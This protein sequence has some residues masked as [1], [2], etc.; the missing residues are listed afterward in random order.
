MYNKAKQILL[1]EIRKFRVKAQMRRKDA[2]K[3]D[4]DADELQ[5]QADKL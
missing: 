2:I 3:F 1:N 5:K 4:A